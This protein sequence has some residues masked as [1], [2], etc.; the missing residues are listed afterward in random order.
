MTEEDRLK[1]VEERDGLEAAIKFA[2]QGIGIYVKAAIE[3][4]KYKDSIKE[5]TRFLNEHGYD[6]LDIIMTKKELKDEK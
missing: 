3:S 1:F 5:Y 2:H 6:K 4:S